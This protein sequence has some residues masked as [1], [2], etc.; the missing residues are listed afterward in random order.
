MKSRGARGHVITSYSIHY[1][2]LYEG[3]LGLGGRAVDL[4]AQHHVGEDGPLAQ[5]EVVGAPVEDVG[6][7]TSYSIH[8]TKLYDASERRSGLDREHY[9]QRQ[10]RAVAEPVLSL[11]GL[12]FDRIVGDDR[13]L[14]L[15]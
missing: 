10:V 15:F 5:Q 11:L 4:V 1:T 13:Q 9:V 12:D 7:I 6:V 3:A 14:E 8:Y 2:K